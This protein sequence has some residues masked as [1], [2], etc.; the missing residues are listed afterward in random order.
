MQIEDV[1]RQMRRLH[2]ELMFE[3]DPTKEVKMREQFINLQKEYS[4]LLYEKNL[5]IKEDE[6]IKTT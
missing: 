6:N 2:K 5:K 4:K 3:K 1:L